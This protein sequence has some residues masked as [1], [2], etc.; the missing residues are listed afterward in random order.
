LNSQGSWIKAANSADEWGFM[1]PERAP[2]DLARTDPALWSLIASQPDGQIRHAGGL[3][4]WHRFAP[5][6]ALSRASVTDGDNFIVLASEV[7]RAEWSDLFSYIRQTFIIIACVLLALLV[8]SGRF[9]YLKQRSVAEL[10]ESQQMFER[11]FENGPDA[12]ILINPTGIIVRANA[13]IETVFRCPRTALVGQS[14]EKLIAEDSQTRHGRQLSEYFADPKLRG[15]NSNLELSAARCDGSN[16]PADV[17]FSPVETEQGRLSLAVI[18]DITDRKRVEQMHLQF[19]ALFE[20]LPGSYLVLKPDLTIAAVSDA[21]LR[22]TMTTREGIL[23]RNLFDV[24]PDNPDE[25][26]ATGVSN[27][28]ASLD[29]VLQ[30]KK[31]DTMA[32]QKYDIRRPDGMFVERY[33]SPINSPVLGM[34]GQVEYIIHRVEDVTEFVKQ[35][36]DPKSSAVS[37]GLREQMETMEAE[38]YRSSQEVQSANERLREA[39]RE[40]E[41]FSYSVSHDLRAPLRHIDGFVNRLEKTAGPNLD[42]TG[43]RCLE[44]ISKSAKHMGNL[45]DDLLVFSR[46]GRTEMRET[47]VDLEQMVKDVVGGMQE[48]TKQRNITFKYGALPVVRGDPAMLQQVFI[49]L[50]GNAVKYTRTRIH[51]EIAIASSETETEF[52]LSV[53]DN[54][55]GF[56]MQYAHKLFGVF[57]RLHRAEEFEGTGIGLANVRRIISRH[58]G[59]TWAEG[60]LDEGAVLYF[61]LPKQKGTHESAETN[62]AG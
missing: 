40:L 14:V 39:N 27:L 21:Y 32:I 4:T 51:A 60:K 11:L 61:S 36:R 43:R 38:I 56:D 41:S 5:G 30:N 34:D 50:I 42:E 22:A 17:T 28:H 15:T 13:Q 12:A 47:K 24:F 7:S 52:I 49:N 23:G 16:F 45:I 1:L 59:R 33:W 25:P 8:M 29:R 46:M 18:R 53:R 58:G 54:G 2:R 3:F 48:E 20:S 57:Q 6:D 62:T 37:T 55:V 44:I 31:S 9:F 35:K 10:R 26:G 19:R